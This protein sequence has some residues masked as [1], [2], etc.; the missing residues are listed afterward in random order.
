M[1]GSARLPSYAMI[2]IVRPEVL[3]L[4]T[5][6]SLAG[7]GPLPEDGAEQETGLAGQAGR[8]G[9]IDS[10]FDTVPPPSLGPLTTPACHSPNRA[11]S[12]T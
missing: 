5:R 9:Q 10:G 1:P 3:A 8:A 6:R 2:A 11:G 7:D 12:V 4:W